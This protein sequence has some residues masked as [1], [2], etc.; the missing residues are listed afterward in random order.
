MLLKKFNVFILLVLFYDYFFINYGKP[1]LHNVV[2]LPDWSKRHFTCIEIQNVKG[3]KRKVE[4]TGGYSAL[5]GSSI[6]NCSEQSIVH[7]CSTLMDVFTIQS[8]CSHVEKG[9]QSVWHL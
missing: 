2:K 6:L 9:L 7:L 5:K 4:I 8:S 3:F 1:G